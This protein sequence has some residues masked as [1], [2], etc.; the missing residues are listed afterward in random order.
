MIK[1]IESSNAKINFIKDVLN[2]D[3]IVYPKEL[4]GTYQSVADRYQKNKESYILAY[5]GD[6]LIGYIC[7]F[8]LT[9]KSYKKV[10]NCKESYDDNLTSKDIDT[11][12]INQENNIFIISVAVLP[13]YQKNGIG[14]T[15]IQEM[16]HFLDNK[17]KEGIRINSIVAEAVSFQGKAL[18]ERAN[19]KKEQQID[20]N[21]DLYTY[22][23]NNNST[24]T[25][26]GFI[27][28]AM[29]CE[30]FNV[31]QS[32]DL[33]IETLNQISTLES[34]EKFTCDLKRYL[35]KKNI[36]YIIHDDNDVILKKIDVDLYL[37]IWNNIVTL[38]LKMSN[39]N[40]DPSYIL[41]N[42]SS[43]KLIFSI[44]GKDIT[45]NEILNRY[46]LNKTGEIKGLITDYEDYSL[47]QK[48]SILAGEQFFN[49]YITG[50]NITS[51][52]LKH[53]AINNIANYNFADMFVSKKNVLYVFNKSVSL[54]NREYYEALIIYIVEVLCMQIN[55]ISNNNNLI[56]DSFKHNNFEENIRI[57]IDKENAKTAYV[58]DSEVFKYYL[59]QVLYNDIAKEFE[60][61]KVKENYLNNYKLYE[62][63]K[64]NYDSKILKK[65]TELTKKYFSLY[66]MLSCF[67]T[68]NTIVGLIFS[69][70]IE[71]EALQ[72]IIVLSV[73]LLSLMCFIILFI[74]SNIIKKNVK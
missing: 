63:V 52:E 64:R 34:N 13:N 2:I 14:A 46:N 38:I 48:V 28:C 20:Q 51:K 15:L 66:T 57:T 65:S 1:Y 33:F 69:C 42:F 16:F 9:D 50:Y 11:Y 44:D 73:G 37:T 72:S 71:D 8:P 3:S 18:L 68:L 36:Q 58:W 39:I 41:D 45:L 54:E 35:I 47:N 26:F 59:A 32:S 23:Y 5:L 12:N 67:S 7:F 30:I 10:I 25:V 40:I 56:L 55:V 24:T 31:E 17:R 6:I 62:E 49:G 70:F 74:I 61:E 19:F 29:R 53:K 43:E 22:I 4:Q 21:Y 60:I 27:P